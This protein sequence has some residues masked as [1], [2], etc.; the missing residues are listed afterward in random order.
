MLFD[1]S[2]FSRWKQVNS[3]ALSFQGT[4]SSWKFPNTWR[5]F[6]FWYEFEEIVCN[7]RG[8]G[9]YP[10][11]CGG[12]TFQGAW[13]S[14]LPPS[15]FFHAC[16]EIKLGHATID[17]FCENDPGGLPPALCFSLM[18]GNEIGTLHYYV[19][20]LRYE[21][22]QSTDKDAH[23]TEVL[24]E[25]T[26]LEQLIG[27]SRNFRRVLSRVTGIWVYATIIAASLVNY[28]DLIFLLLNLTSIFVFISVGSEN[29]S[30]YLQF[31]GP[32]PCSPIPQ[33]SCVYCTTSLVDAWYRIL[34]LCSPIP[35]CPCVH[36][37][38]RNFSNRKR[39]CYLELCSLIQKCSCLHVK[40][41]LSLCF[42]GSLSFTQAL[43]SF[44]LCVRCQKQ[45]SD[46]LCFC[47]IAFLCQTAHW[48]FKDC[49]VEVHALSTQ[50][51]T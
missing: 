29:S 41:R 26:L 45:T 38:F 11:S 4:H 39:I 10:F 35:H 8:N 33:C 27:P 13:N 7:P 28:P 34:E 19:C 22:V 30:V 40:H 44:L 48:Q 32:E 23:R 47:V 20:F 49:F 37:V 18:H 24:A 5:M 46:R 14:G 50:S 21:D 12:R 36:F 16:M 43:V 9:T 51:L 42:R 25:Q 1:S 6:A 2:S 15:L 3:S 17:F 31:L